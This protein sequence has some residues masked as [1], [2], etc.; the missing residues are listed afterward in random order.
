MRRVDNETF[1]VIGSGAY[2]A[3]YGPS[4]PIRSMHN[5]DMISFDGDGVFTNGMITG[6]SGWRSDQN[7]ADPRTPI[8]GLQ[9]N[10]IRRDVD[11]MSDLRCM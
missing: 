2:A 3:A 8:D 11:Q 6:T 1:Q 7:G 5:F 9:S 10:N 4:N